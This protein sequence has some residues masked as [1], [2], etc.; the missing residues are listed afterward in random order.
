M[1]LR[2]RTVTN[3]HEWSPILQDRYL[4]AMRIVL[5]AASSSVHVLRWANAMAERGHEVHLVSQH[6]P[7]PG[8]H[9]GIR[10]HRLPFSGVAGYLLNGPSFQTLLRRIRPD[11]VNAHYATGYGTLARWTGPFPL[12]INVWGSDV[13]EFPD[14]GPL[15]KS[16][17]LGN[18]RRAR[19]LISTSAFMA[20]RT[21]SLALDLPPLSMVPFGVD[22]ER[23]SPADPKHNADPLVIGTVKTL[24]PKYGIDTLLRAFRLVM[25]RR[26][27][28]RLRIVGG[29]PEELALKA[30]AGQIGIAEQVDFTLSV[31]HT[32]VPDALRG[33]DI[34]VALSRADSETFGVAVIEASACGLPVVVSDAGGLP[35]VVVDGVTG[36]VVR[37]DDPQAA[38]DR[39]LELIAS[40][41]L[42]LSMGRSGREHV[43][44]QYEWS[45]CVDRQIAV[46]DRVISSGGTT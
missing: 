7:I 4:D 16:W 21:A 34:F 14:Q 42:R 39:I 33:M 18:L 38:A 17:L 12:V 8:F 3:Q 19:H 35:E 32:D 13:F 2:V 24:A 43:L 41:E 29:G 30:L 45:S 31:Q 11:V 46:F 22:C 37:R 5:L 25:A 10:T 28:V 6:V 9:E 36:H 1:A 15:H 20:R 40:P 44:A 26:P 27:E 23:F